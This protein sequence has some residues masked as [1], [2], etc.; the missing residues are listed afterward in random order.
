[1]GELNN[2]DPA[3]ETLF[4]SGGIAVSPMEPVRAENGALYA[5]IRLQFPLPDGKTFTQ[6][7]VVAMSADNMRKL[8]PL[9]AA[10]VHD[11]CEALKRAEQRSPDPGQEKTP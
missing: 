4:V 7:V 2:R 8:R 6:P 9:V 3:A 10:A 5:A 11:S 1:M